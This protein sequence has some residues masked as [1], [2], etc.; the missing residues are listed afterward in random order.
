[1]FAGYLL[2]LVAFG[3]VLT[4]AKS[5]AVEDATIVNPD[6]EIRNVLP[7]L[8][9]PDAPSDVAPPATVDVSLD[10]LQDT[11]KISDHDIVVPY[12]SRT[13]TSTGGVEQK[14]GPTYWQ[15]FSN[16]VSYLIQLPVRM[17][18]SLRDA[19]W[20]ATGTS[21]EGTTDE[22]ILSSV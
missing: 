2:S 12:D 8:R 9:E 16:Y 15:S 10:Q 22:V 13:F 17:L 3:A 14:R 18:Y 7:T 21:N 4:A 11:L 6:E 20:R 5:V 1:M 19:V